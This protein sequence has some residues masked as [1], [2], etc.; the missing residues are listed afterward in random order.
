MDGLFRCRGDLRHFKRWNRFADKRVQFMTVLGAGHFSKAI[1]DRAARQGQN[2]T[3]TH[4]FTSLSSHL[5]PSVMGIIH[6]PVGSQ[7]RY[8]VSVHYRNYRECKSGLR[9]VQT[10]CE[11]CSPAACESFRRVSHQL[12]QQTY[13]PFPKVHFSSTVIHQAHLLSL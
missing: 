7:L 11:S 9:S 4:G 13:K 6:V 12:L 1:F 8:I 5:N 3:P 2:I 10:S